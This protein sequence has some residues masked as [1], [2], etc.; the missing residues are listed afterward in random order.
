M[1]EYKFSCPY[2]AQ[3]LVGTEAWAGQSL[4]CPNCQKEFTVPQPPS[5]EP[6]P[7]PAA[8]PPMLAPAG[9]RIAGATNEAAA[10]PPL[11]NPASEIEQQVL[12]GGRYVIFQY[13]IS[14]LVMSFR[15][16]S[17]IVYVPPGKDGAG[18]AI[19]NSVI[20][21]FAGWWG[22]PWGPIWTI[23]SVIKNV[24]GGTDV[25]QAI[26]ADQVG[27]ARAAQIMAQRRIVPATGP[28]MKLFR[29][30]MAIVG[31]WLLL[32]VV[33]FV[34]AVAKGVTSGSNTSETR[35]PVVA[36][37]GFPAAN[38]QIN[39]NHGTVAFGNSPQA[40]VIA[41]EFATIMRPLSKENGK[42]SR[43]SATKN[44]FLTHCELRDD[45]CAIIVHVP[46][47][48]KYSAA[49]QEKIGHLAWA[50]AQAALAKNAGMK[51]GMKLAVGL[52]GAF[53]YDRVLLGT[54]FT[55]AKDK[56]LGLT[57]TITSSEPE[58]ALHAFFQ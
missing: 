7:L 42:S 45:R 28:G 39:I 46:E 19:G 1:S 26:L 4:Q 13:C 3:H 30:G 57:E 48:R 54:Q 44:E 40:V 14:I 58:K 55:D 43:F 10:P 53:L 56:N 23:S 12:A 47:L 35:S 32:S 5:H 9:L 34:V 25:T 33:W 16:S 17:G 24:R 41:Q 6:P 37:A 22:I 29:I 2:C 11:N 27:A 20:S 36:S 38:K 52:R 51:P 15:R 8:A 49:D 31:L 18:A 21:L 50:T